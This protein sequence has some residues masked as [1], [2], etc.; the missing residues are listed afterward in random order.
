MEILLENYRDK[1]DMESIWK[2]FTSSQTSLIWFSSNIWR[3]NSDRFMAQLSGIIKIMSLIVLGDF[4]T[5][6]A[7]NSKSAVPKI[8]GVIDV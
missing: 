7:G 1:V 2:N 5:D 8:F 6:S 3:S 4:A